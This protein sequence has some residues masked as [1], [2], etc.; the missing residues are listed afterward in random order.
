MTSFV[1]EERIGYTFQWK[2]ENFSY[3]WHK[4]GYKI[5]SPDFVLDRFGNTKWNL[6]LYPRGDQNQNYIGFYLKRKGEHGPKYIEIN[7]ELQFLSKEGY[8]LKAW[9]DLDAI[10]EKDMSRGYPEF[11]KRQTVLIDERETYLPNDTLTAVCQIRNSEQRVKLIK[12]FFARTVIKVNRASFY[13]NI[14]RFRYLE[15][16]QKNSL[17]IKSMANKKMLTLNFY[18]EGEECS[19]ESANVSISLHER[20]IKFLILKVFLVDISGK[21][22]NCGQKAFFCNDFDQNMTILL[23]FTRNYII[24]NRNKYL[25]DGELCLKCECAYSNEFAFQ[26]TEEFDLGVIFSESNHKAF[27]NFN[28]NVEQPVFLATFFKKK[29]FATI[30]LLSCIIHFL[31][32]F[33]VLEF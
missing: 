9:R 30:V 22:F 2:I 13:W 25:V 27:E 17:K 23:K 32:D 5:A 24:E 12:K 3:S 21:Q 28:N 29:I 7:C 4:T 16:N 31:L 10:F 33:S 14:E 19:L 26:A 1:V 20:K 6:N 8:L 11:I 15:H 18:L